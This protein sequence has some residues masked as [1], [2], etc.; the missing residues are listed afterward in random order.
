MTDLFAA[1]LAVVAARTCSAHLADGSIDV[2]FHAGDLLADVPADA[3]FDLVYENL[4]NL[5][6]PTGTELAAR[7]QH[8]SLLRRARRAAVP[9]PFGRYLLAL[10]HRC[11]LEARPARP[12]PA[13]A[14]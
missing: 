12:R 5:P 4:P 7:H 6:A 9:E 11:L 14:C 8:R 13:A 1:S 3:R 2:A 10:H